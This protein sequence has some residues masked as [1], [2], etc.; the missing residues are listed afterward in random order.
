MQQRILNLLKIQLKKCWQQTILERN[1]PLKVINPLPVPIDSSDKKRLNLDPRYIN[2]Y[3]YNGRIKNLMIRSVS[4]RFTNKGY[5][6][7]F[8]L[9][10]GYHHT[11]LFA[12]HQAYLSFSW[13]IKRG[14][15]YFI[16]TIFCIYCHFD[17]FVPNISR[18][19]WIICQRIFL[20]DTE[21]DINNN[22]LSI[23][24]SQITSI[25]NKIGLLTNNIYISAR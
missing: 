20:L 9:K 21:I 22:I 4:K 24:S 5:L 15:K 2:T 13:D 12:S 17:T 10:N 18:S 3:F 25:L 6:F 16:F 19:I 14:A 11:D 23:P 7:K 1:H 8:D